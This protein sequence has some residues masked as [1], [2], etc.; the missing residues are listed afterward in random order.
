MTAGSGADADAGDGPRHSAEWYRVRFG[1]DPMRPGAQLM[2]PCDGGPSRV[3]LETLPPRL[4]I[5][6]RGGV[7]VLA[8]DGP[9]HAW[10]YHF[11]SLLG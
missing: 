5:E 8:D 2:I 1:A 4:E 11:V 6:V 7:Y 3:T 9:V 10:S